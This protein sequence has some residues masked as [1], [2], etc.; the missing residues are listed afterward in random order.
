MQEMLT[1]CKTNTSANQF[2]R[3]WYGQSITEICNYTYINISFSENSSL[4]TTVMLFY[5]NLL[6]LTII[7]F[8][9]Q[10]WHF[11][12]QSMSMLIG[13]VHYI[14][15]FILLF[16]KGNFLEFLCKP[17]TFSTVH[18]MLLC[19]MIYSQPL[20]IKNHLLT[21]LTITNFQYFFQ[22]IT[23]LY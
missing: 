21:E 3:T 13:D 2:S 12:Y 5:F 9:R 8:S 14:K 20:I 6:I 15:S 18:T 22:I 16:L 7:L 1:I 23:N 19:L 17:K 4:T 10:K 11:F